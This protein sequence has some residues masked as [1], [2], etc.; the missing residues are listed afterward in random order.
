MIT[1]AIRGKVATP[2]DVTWEDLAQLPVSHQIANAQELGAKRPGRAVRLPAVLAL[3]GPLAEADYL[4]LHASL[5]NFHASIPLSPILER[6]VVIY[7]QDDAPLP[8]SAGGPFRLF[9]ADHTACHV[10][11]IDECANVKFI[12]ELELTV[13]KG[14]DNRPEDEEAHE[15]LHQQEQNPPEHGG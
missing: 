15:Q 13:G 7:A 6:A 1:L 5:D 9:I 3:A 4:G 14:H 12:D 10:S 8:A 11:E 2:V